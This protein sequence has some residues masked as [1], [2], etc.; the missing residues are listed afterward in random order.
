MRR[1]A[2]A[3]ALVL[4]LGAAPASAAARWTYKSL[5]ADK[6][7]EL[8]SKEFVPVSREIHRAWDAN[9]NARLENTEFYGGLYRV[10]DA[11]RNGRL[12]E[13][14]YTKA[15]GAWGRGKQPLAYGMLDANR[16][17][18]LARDEFVT[19]FSK[20]GHLFSGWD[21]DRG[22]WLSEDEFNEGLHRTWGGE[23]GA[24]GERE[25]EENADDDWF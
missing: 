15:W 18:W 1:A 3:L 19:G 7:L 6:N 20:A 14:E 22:G 24:L 2:T 23:D 17:G 11:D 16:D 4:A 5:D 12:T 8:T 13:A 9:K 21:A 10:W 25:F